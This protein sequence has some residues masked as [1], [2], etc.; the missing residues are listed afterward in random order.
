MSQMRSADYENRHPRTRGRAGALIALLLTALVALAVF[1]GASAPAQDATTELQNKVDE[2]GQNQSEQGG[3]E[4]TINR[5][6]AE[7]NSLIAQES[8]ARRREAAVQSQLDA[9]QAELDEATAA[10]ER[11]KVHLEAIRAHYDRAIKALEGLLVDIYKSQ[12]PDTLSVLLQSANWSDV[13]AQ[14]EYLDQI[15]DYDNAVVGRVREL[16]DEIRTLVDQLTESHARVKAARDEIQ[17]QRDQLASTRAEIES[18]HS[19]LVAARGAR[20]STLA[21]LQAREKSLEGDLHKMGAPVPGE[22]ATLLPNGDAVPPP[23]APLVVKA[24]IEAA[25]QINDLPYVWGGGHG[26]FSD[27]G[28]DCSGAVSYALHGGGLLSSPL[29]ST[30]FTAYGDSGPGSWITIYANSGHVYAV[31]AGLRFDTGGN[32][33]GFGPRFHTDQRSSAGF[34]ARHPSGY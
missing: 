6:N 30:G 12:E 28:Y 27:S 10:L 7:I 11:E 3:L 13:I 14:S 23:N 15:Q 24:V 9:K 21:A 4:A 20:Q 26:S 22:Q 16:R 18:Q 8:E 25:N 32:G 2:L 1:G 33:G 31:I 5:Q 17:A 29:D 34:I 19:S